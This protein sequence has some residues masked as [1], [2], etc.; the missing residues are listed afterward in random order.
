[1]S[2]VRRASRVSYRVPPRPPV[3]QFAS[4]EQLVGALE[5]LLI[6]GITVISVHWR[7]GYGR[8]QV[9]VATV[10]EFVEAKRLLGATETRS[11]CL[12][13]YD[14]VSTTDGLVRL[15]VQ[16]PRQARPAGSHPRQGA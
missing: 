8:E 3:E 4:F 2:R 7:P 12:G 13:D 1:M 11:L 16:V 14:L 15:A 9:I 10:D 5:Q 6:A